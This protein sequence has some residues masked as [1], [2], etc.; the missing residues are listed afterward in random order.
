MCALIHS[1]RPVSAQVT[2][3][4]NGDGNLDNDRLPGVSRNSYTGPGYFSADAR[5]ARKLHV[6]ER[7]RL[8]AP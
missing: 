8:E 1:G 7:W 5:L 6:S 3:D 2:G 4:M